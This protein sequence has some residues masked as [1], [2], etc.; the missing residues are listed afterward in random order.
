MKKTTISLMMMA[1]LPSWMN[2]QRIQQKLG[3]SVV[4]VTDNATSKIL[5]TWR[6]LAQEPD[7]CY[8]NL[9]MRPKGGTE[10]TKV[11]TTPISKTNY[12]TTRTQIP[13]DTELAVTM[14]YGDTESDKSTPFLFKKQAYK[15]VFFDFDFETTVLNPNNYKAKYAWPMDLDGNGEMDAILVDREYC[16]GSTADPQCTTKSHKL[17]AYTLDGKCLWT[18]D[19][20]PNVRIDEG[21]NDMVL[22]YDINCDGKCEVIVKSSDETRFWDASKNTWGK[23][24]NGSNVA[25]TDGDGISD[26]TT[27]KKRNP[28]FYISVIDGKTGAE[29]DC[30]ELNYSEVHDGIDQYGRDNRADYMDDNEGTEYAFMCGHFAICYFDGIHPSLAMECLDRRKSDGHHNYVFAWEYDWNG[31]KPTNWHHSYTWS[32]N[33]KTPWPAEFHQLR[34]ADTDGDGIDEMLEG[35]YG[36]NTKKGMV[37]SAGIGHGDRYDVS[38]IDPDRPGMEVFAIQQANL[39]GQVLYDA[40]TGEHIKEWYLPNVYDVG[41]GRCMDVD[42]DH[43]GYEIFSLLPNLYDCKGNVIK[44]GSTSY[45]YEGIWWDG[46]LQRELIGSPGG[47]G[48]SSNVMVTKYNGNRLIQFSKESDWAVHTGWAVRPA[49]MGDMTGDWREE[50]VLMKQNADS[51][52]GLVG[53]STDLPTDYSFYTLQEDPHY[54]LDCT[55]RGYYQMPCTGFYLGGDMPYPPLPP[56]M[57]TDLRWQNGNSWNNGGNGFTSFDQKQ[58]LNFADGKSV[59]FDI[60]GDNSQTINLNGQLKPKAVY[61]MSPRE[62]DYTFGGTGTLEGDMELWKS[63]LG[64]TTFNNDFRFTGRTVISEGTLCVNG[65]I[66]GPIDLRAKGTLAG[67]TTVNGDIKFEGA[68]N[69]EGCRLMPGNA[70]NKFGVITFNK[71]LTI[72]GEV[73]IEVSAKDGQAGHIIVN[74]D[75]TFDGTNYFTI[76]QVDGK[77]AEGSYTLAE[78]TGKLT[79]DANLFKIRGL[80]GINYDIKVD[81]KKVILDVNGTRAPMTNVVWTG[82]DNNVWDYKSD[83]FKTETS[84]TPFVTD[85]EVVFNDQSGN[86]NITVNDLMVTKGVT[87]DFNDGTY[88]FSGEGG[89]SGEGGVTKNGNGEV[90]MNL[91]NNDYTGATIINGGTLTV[92]DLA[93]GGKKS[94][95]GAASA[96]E[97]N[98][99]INGATLKVNADNMATDRV[100]TLTDTA[101]INVAKSSGSVSLKGRVKGSGYLVKEGKGQLNFNYGGTNPF[102]GLILRDGKVSQGIWNSSFGNTGSPM[103]LEGGELAL[104]ENKSMSTVPEFNYKATV[105]EGKSSKISGSYRSRINGSFMGQ[106]E[107]TIVSTGVRSDIGANFSQFEGTLK[108]QG[109]NFR[110]MDNVTDMQKTAL[111]LLE[112]AAVGHYKSGSADAN[113]ITTKIGSLASDA[114]D[115]SLGNGKDTYEIGYDNTNTTYKG[116]FKAVTIKKYGTGSLTLPTNGSTSNIDVYGGELIITNNPYSSSPV[117]VT[118]GSIVVRNGG[119]LRG[120]GC[121]MAVTVQKGGTIAAGTSDKLVSTLKTNGNLILQE[122]AT[123]KV[124]ASVNTSGKNVNDKFK[125]GGNITHNGD[126]IL[127]DVAEDYTIAAGDELSIFTVSGKQTGSYVLQTNA[128]GKNITWDDSRLLSDGVL[129]VKDVTASIKAVEISDD[130]EVDVYATD[131]TLLRN[132]VKFGHALEG[133]SRGVY[134][135]NGHKVIKK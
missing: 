28:P 97:G 20:G 124:K 42:P 41:R 80:D 117:S 12:E 122:G 60:S 109:S 89:I 85:D 125:I 133:L 119:T 9:Y 102:A 67:V 34:V 53:Y 66:N 123:L 118:S 69:Y 110:L 54:R 46:D 114:T 115:C 14:V 59:V 5:V 64:T 7:S 91:K 32:R 38:D 1:M 74:G 61:V 131:G 39:L 75:L 113:A 93:D 16:G 33:D 99:Q 105:P 10:Y 88:T 130:T 96:S 26:Y 103:L 65:T 17:Q 132:Q 18:V 76:D 35:G 51:S 73:Y 63:M 37:Y 43:K 70:D 27:Q 6:K 30:S 50:I 25:D 79:A 57:V 134:I 22:A 107:L 128:P 94:C 58:S 98:L 49:F 48:Y 15:D 121:A 104:I 77:V 95:I 108:A 72:P 47:S 55:T 106:G 100:I 81:G 127:V 82:S 129:V 40:K 44:E 83:N 31:G 92:A 87:F 71:S 19:M 24:A 21:Q 52:T 78:C 126:T 86:R 3:R 36:V 4:A 120:N 84:N 29:I 112:G 8:Y 68:L 90:I 2:A 116:I 111:V 56:T 13:Y 23:Y 45:P 11:N 62:H 135:V 101:T